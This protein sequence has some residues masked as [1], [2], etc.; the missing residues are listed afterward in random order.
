MDERQQL[1]R[2]K[3]LETDLE[4]HTRYFFKDQKGYS[5]LLAAF[6]KKVLA[7]F[8]AVIDGKIKDLLILLPP[9]HGKTEMAKAFCTMGFAQNPAAEF[10][11]GCS[12]KQLALDCSSSVRNTIKSAEFKKFWNINIRIDADA[13]SLWK[14]EEGGGFWAGSFGS[15]IV[16]YAAGKH[17][18]ALRGSQYKFG[19]AAIVDDPLKEQDRFRIIERERAINF[20]RDTLPFRMNDIRTTPRVV[21]MQPL[22]P[23]DLGQHIKKNCPEFTVIELPALDSDNNVLCPEMYNYDDLMELKGKTSNEAWMSKFML[24]PISM[25]GNILKTSYL[26]YYKELPFLKH[27][28]IVVDTAQKTEERHDYTVFQCW[29]KGYDGGIYLI[30]QFRGKLEYKDLK[31][32]FK[33]FWNKHNSVENYDL[34]KYGYL[35]AAYIE[36]KSS[37]TQVIQETQ[38]EG[39]IPVVAVQRNRSKYERAVDVCLPKLEAGYIFIPDEA[40]FCQDLKDEMESFTGQEDS[41]ASILKLDKKKTW[42]DQVDCL[43]SACETGFTEIVNNNDIVANFMDRKRKLNNRQ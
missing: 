11:Y 29:G 38:A 22:H 23:E 15:P 26:K 24:T 31:Q 14:T 7:A 9:R 17:P 25:G 10:I 5:F 27:R 43:I 39:N 30:D 6:H 34:R 42:D 3:I 20:F 33:D 35:K 12:D 28:W 8:Q 32:R 16:G 41:K 4:Y 37:G 40:P 36:D 2:K 13:K 18:N 19:G 21:F 1:A